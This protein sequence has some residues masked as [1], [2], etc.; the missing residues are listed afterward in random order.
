MKYNL[1]AIIKLLSCESIEMRYVNNSL[2]KI[3]Y[4]S[5]A[6]KRIVIKCILKYVLVF[7]SQMEASKFIR[8]KSRAC[9]TLHSP[10]PT[11]SQY[12]E[13]TVAVVV[14][15]EFYDDDEDEIKLSAKQPS[16]YSDARRK[17]L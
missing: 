8:I 6:F 2:F 16:Y 5:L 14:D 13:S 11:V 10:H 17:F 1:N 7:Q 9:V 3:I 4:C 15:D 12:Q